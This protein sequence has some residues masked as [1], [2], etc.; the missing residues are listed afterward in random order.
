MNEPIA[1]IGSSCRFPGESSTPEK[2]WELNQR[3]RD[4]LR[5]FPKKPRQADNSDDQEQLLYGTGNIA[6]SYFIS[7]DVRGFDHH[8]FRMHPMEASTMDPQYRLTLECVYEALESAGLPME[9]LRGSSTAV[10]AGLTG[11]DYS[12]ILTRD[13]LEVPRYTAT[14][15]Y[16]SM[17]ANR[18][19]YF[20]DLSGPS[21]TVDT[22]FCGANLLLD[23]EQYLTAGNLGMLSPSGRCH[24]WDTKADG[25]ARG[26]GV[27]VIIL[28]RLDIALR[29]GDNIG[30]IVRETGVNQD[31]RTLGITRPSPAAQ[32]ALIQRTYTRAGLDC[33]K[34]EDRCQ[35][36]EA[37][38]TGT[39]G[40]AVEAEAIQSAFFDD[41]EPNSS[42]E[43]EPPLY[44]GSMKTIVG[45]TEGCSGLA[46]ILRAS[47]AIQKGYIPPNFGFERLHPDIAPFY[48]GLEVPQRIKPWP[49]LPQG[50]PRRVSVN[51]FGFGGTNAHAILEQHLLTPKQTGSRHIQEDTELA[52]ALPFVLSADSDW[53]LASQLASYSKFLKENPKVNMEHLAWTL[54][55][56][57]STLSVRAIFTASTVKELSDKI[58]HVVFL[59]RLV[60]HEAPGIH[61]HVSL[62]RPRILGI[63]TGMGVPW[64]GISDLIRT[65]SIVRQTVS[66]LQNSLSILPQKFRPSWSLRQELKAL[67]SE[68]SIEYAATQPSLSQS[69]STSIQIIMVDLL[70][71]SGVQLNAVVG[72]SAGEIAAAY[73]AGFI[74]RVD[75]IRIAY[76]RGFFMSLVKKN[77]AMLAVNLSLQEALSLIQTSG[78]PLEVAAVNSPHSVT[79]SGELELIESM[80]KILQDKKCQTR[81]LTGRIP[82]HT[83]HMHRCSEAYLEALRNLDIKTQ[84]P[85]QGFCAWFSSVEGHGKQVYNTSLAAEYW[86][87]SLVC[88]VRFDKAVAQALTDQGSVDL[89]L[90]FGPLASLETPVLDTIKSVAMHELPYTGIFQRGLGSAEGVA[91]A[92]AFIWAHLGFSAVDFESYLNDMMGQS[93]LRLVPL[94][95]LPALSWN[96]D[97]VFW[98]ESRSSRMHRYHRGLRHNLLGVQ[99][100]ES[101]ESEF[102]WTNTLDIASV[103][104]MMSSIT[105]KDAA[106]PFPVAMSMALSAAMIA[107]KGQAVSMIILEDCKVYSLERF[108]A[109]TTHMDTLFTLRILKKRASFVSAT[110]QYYTT[111]SE[112]TNSLQMC[113]GVELRIIFDLDQNKSGRQSLDTRSAAG[114][115]PL[116]SPA[117]LQAILTSAY[118]R[119]GFNTKH[120]SLSKI[121]CITVYPEL[122]LQA[123]E[124]QLSFKSSVVERRG[125][126]FIDIEVLGI[127]NSQAP[128][129]IEGI[130]VSPPSHTLVANLPPHL[131]GDMKIEQD[132]AD[133]TLK[134][135]IVTVDYEGN[136]QVL[137]SAFL[138]KLKQITELSSDNGSAVEELPL[139]QLGI[140]SLGAT[141]IRTWFLRELSISFSVR[142]VLGG[143]S[144]R[145][146]VDQAF[147]R[148]SP[149]STT[150]PSIQSTDSQS[151]STDETQSNDG[152]LLAP[153]T[154]EQPARSG[155]ERTAQLSHAQSGYWFTQCATNDKTSLNVS[156]YYHFAGDLNVGRL[157]R[158]VDL[159]VQRHESLRTCFFV[160]EADNGRP[161][162][163]VLMQS[164]CVLE[165][166]IIFGN[167]DV[168]VHFQALKDHI[169]DLDSGDT[170]KIILLKEGTRS[171]YLLVGYHHMVMDGFSFQQIFLPELEKAYTGQTLP[172]PVP[173]FCDHAYQQRH[174]LET[175]ETGATEVAYW[176]KVFTDLP[177]CL[178]LFP[179][180]RV[181]FRLPQTTY[182][183]N[184]ERLVLDKTTT[185]QIRKVS[186]ENNS[187]AFHFHLTI[188]SILLFRMLEI[189]DVCIGVADANRND[190][191]ETRVLGLLLNFLP[192]RFLYLPGNNFSGSLQNVRD[193][194]YDALS[195]SRLPFSILLE[196]LQVSRSS[197]S[198]PLFQ[199][200]INYRSRQAEK[201]SFAG[202][203]GRSH[204]VQLTKAGYDL[205]LD[206]GETPDGETEIVFLCQAAIIPQDGA[207]V[208]MNTYR[209][210]LRQFAHQPE[211]RMSACSLYDKQDVNRA[212][213]AG[214]GPLIE[215]GWPDTLIH[216]VDEMARKFSSAI[217]TSDGTTTWTYRELRARYISIATILSRKGV[218]AHSHVAVFQEPGCDWVASMLAIMYIGAVYVPLDQQNPLTRLAVILRCCDPA[219]VICDDSTIDSSP[220]L[221]C[222]SDKL[223]N[224]SN[225][226]TDR[227]HL[228][229]LPPVEAHG[230]DRAVVLFS[231]GSTGTPKGI[232][233]SHSNLVCKIESFSHRFRLAGSELVTL[234]H[235]AYSFDVSLDQIFVGLANG[236]RVHIASKSIRGDS[237]ELAATIVRERVTFVETTPS[238]MQ[239]IV[240]FG[241]AELAGNKSWT[242]ALC[243]GEKFPES[244]KMDFRE[245]NLPH[246]RL[247][248]VYGPTEA[249]IAVTHFEISYRSIRHET[250]EAQPIPIGPVLPNYSISIVDNNLQPLP[251]GVPGEILIGGGGVALGYLDDALSVK[252]FIPDPFAS[253]AFR[254]KGWDRVFRTGDR[255]RMHHEGNVSFEG[256][257]DGNT[258]VKL[259]GLRVDLGD[260]ESSI[261]S[262][263][264][265]LV[266]NVAVSMRGDPAFLVGH[267]V[268]STQQHQSA[269]P[270]D[271]E[272]FLR[273]LLPKLQLPA[274][275]IPA[276]L[277]PVDKIPITNHGKRD[278]QAIA[279]LPMRSSPSLHA[280]GTKSDVD[281]SFLFTKTQAALK[282]IWI[283]LLSED[284]TASRP[285]S[286]NSE[287]FE[288]GGNSLL[289]I[290]LRKNIQN[291]FDINIWLPTL[292]EATSLGAMAEVIEKEVSK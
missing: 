149:D 88:R 5:K 120:S 207:S 289:L 128:I 199:T 273:D 117:K 104:N 10:F 59:S 278:Q 157:E 292:M 258:M 267:V 172:Q 45:H 53:G 250:D 216:H 2:L 233:I 272:S 19:S 161:M 189:D 125:D 52:T 38:G 46:G 123:F 13:P 247:F 48:K 214:R 56:R 275:M 141:E 237:A 93:Q 261:L 81:R 179:M 266:S 20:F 94:N 241:L 136:E 55:A 183:Y 57:R 243:G 206:I 232:A 24:M 34:F 155:F 164:A 203:L 169:Y 107:A 139:V 288:M 244:L 221:G 228:A 196:E 65:S 90:E 26:E 254:A 126:V 181:T 255:G 224:V 211:V 63:F 194:V 234:Q 127:D 204:Q 132:V 142:D 200:F 185:D 230:N 137:L 109:S 23:S 124:S 51:S 168:G 82:Y 202:L 217:A 40:D 213:E 252:S 268:M 92:L 31:G 84:V 135:E 210:L 177:P 246:L 1:I 4:L 201:G 225:I 75:A 279:A 16:K 35:F 111:A 110:A 7:E 60:G 182:R 222:S 259:R 91:H 73:A 280:L 28:K 290:R 283:Q 229:Q 184:T 83:R 262:A 242:L 87:Q 15:A 39:S 22:A 74:S 236:G 178:P 176:K 256:R 269:P 197:T 186:R 119:Q 165:N 71:S 101:V 30:C 215:S 240:Q 134:D 9:K 43:K 143:A 208:I 14:G 175:G 158:A 151:N 144:A 42:Q 3:P 113:F 271:T 227:Q 99:S 8:F 21:I 170:M 103:S 106:V 86:I 191:D 188:L 220:S 235:T 257:I 29:H 98:N 37:H 248:N 187:S 140:D 174:A 276:V 274:Y 89:V 95:G 291:T 54:C 41:R 72:H 50:I 130:H 138:V 218:V 33:K 150:L 219:A 156:F 58:D 193:L 281:S 6:G 148:L 277:V 80:T 61:P 195:H 270:M 108:H 253:P 78:I 102:R 12:N 287:F 160:D 146:L 27:G 18:I 198:T 69:L 251:A 245:L 32:S 66:E 100:P 97:R 64:K 205:S 67:T 166:K 112:D 190:E 114:A 192:L 145:G 77:G 285:I 171:S 76:Y 173:Q 68:R 284:I 265:G 159:V 153:A 154:E 70:R 17:F 231:S 239:L 129:L 162:Q 105:H 116:I 180:S 282:E 44:V 85:P 122:C 11:T 36:F 121:D 25:Y 238:E 115:R 226:I 118:E 286:T 96:H 79:L 260:V 62:H 47:L 152:M 49:A 223:I 209:N 264:H 167:A 263:A 163:G 147:S 249:T 131:G 212:L 133:L